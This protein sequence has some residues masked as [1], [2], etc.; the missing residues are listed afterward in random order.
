LH[1]LVIVLLLSAIAAFVYYEWAYPALPPVKYVAQF[2][3]GHY[4]CNARGTSFEFSYAGTVYIS[5]RKGRGIYTDSRNG[6]GTS[7][8]LS[9]DGYT[10][11]WW[12]GISQGEVRNTAQAIA[13]GESV[14]VVDED[15]TCHRVWRLDQSL[16][17]IPDSIVFQ[18][19]E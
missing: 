7:H 12:D 8:V 18:H 15:F 3:L 13:Y 10:Y 19:V 1:A 4:I 14:P 9:R 2:P 17:E 16:F 5:D 11:Y 6:A